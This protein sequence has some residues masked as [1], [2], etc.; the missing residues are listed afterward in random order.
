MKKKLESELVSIAHRI[1]QMKDKSSLPQLQEEARALYEKLT[2][3]NFAE[4]HFAGPQP[5][6]G[7]VRA[8]IENDTPK[9]IKDEVLEVPPEVP[10]IKPSVSL[11]ENITTVEEEKPKIPKIKPTVSLSDDP[12]EE[13]TLETMFTKEEERIDVQGD[14]IEKKPEIIIEEIN[15][16][17]TEDLF[18]PA[19]YAADEG[20]SISKTLA[21]KPTY[22]KN[23][24]QDVG[25]DFQESSIKDDHETSE[26]KSKS[27]N[28]ELKKGI[29]IGV[30]DRLAFIKYL[31]NGSS[32]DYNRVL[33]Q[34]N[35]LNSKNGAK[36]FIKNMVKPD[37]NNWEGKK[38]Y[39]DRFIEIVISKY[40]Y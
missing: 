40:E 14:D 35:S 11:N 6:I 17:V 21:S 12:I 18:I 1:L 10:K 19:S 7:Q 29:H 25:G 34:L 27:L 31:F 24:K 30:N 32:A 38:E 22:E 9:I 39:E 28:D 5:T 26:E 23:D 33:S 4:S 8:F 2:V 15:A 13:D 37:Y 16:R 20:I 3:L 36:Q